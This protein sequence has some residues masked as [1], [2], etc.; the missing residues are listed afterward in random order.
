MLSVLTASGDLVTRF[1]TDTDG[2]FKVSLAPGE[3]ILRPVS[4]EN[5]PLPT[6][7]EQPFTV[8]S[9]KFTEL[10]VTYDSGIR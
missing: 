8:F 2:K 6:A 10:I 7:Q 9:D 5:M 3:Y 4:P 1:I